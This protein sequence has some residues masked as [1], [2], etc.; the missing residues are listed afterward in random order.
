M[1]EKLNSYMFRVSAIVILIST[2]AYLFEKNISPYFFAV[3][4]AGVAVSKLN[5]QYNGNNLRI[6]RLFRL[7]KM[8][9]ILYVG[10][11]YFM[12]KPHNQWIPLLLC[13]AALELYTNTII[14]KELNK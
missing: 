6:K 8:A 9:G 12:F 3:A 5:Q 10:A 4:A 13:A 1:K 2:V 14:S 11:S 7:Q